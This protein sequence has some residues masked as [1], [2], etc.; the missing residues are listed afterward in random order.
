MGDITRITTKAIIIATIMVAGI[1]DIVTAEA[2]IYIGPGFPVRP[3]I[4]AI[5]EEC[6]RGALC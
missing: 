4:I 6:R 3:G 2:T 5:G 1:T